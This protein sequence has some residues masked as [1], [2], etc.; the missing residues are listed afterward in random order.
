MKI[1]Q[2]KISLDDLLAMLK[3]WKRA[4]PTTTNKKTPNM[5]GP[6]FDFYSFFWF[7]NLITPLRTPF[8]SRLSEWC[9]SLLSFI[10]WSFAWI[11]KILPWLLHYIIINKR[12][13]NH[14]IIQY[15]II[16]L[17]ILNKSNNTLFVHYFCSSFFVFSLADPHWLKCWKGRKNTSS[18]PGLKF[19]FSRGID[20]NF[21]SWWC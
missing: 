18:N 6:I 15:F 21:G 17:L 2:I 8:F 5:I 11:T 4:E 14:Y 13:I 19:P 1:S 10:C 16:Q 3:I 12:G 20:F 9:F 7:T